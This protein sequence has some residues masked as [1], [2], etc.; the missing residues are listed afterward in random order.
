MCRF[1]VVEGIRDTRLL[2][3]DGIDQAKEAVEGWALARLFTLVG[4]PTPEIQTWI[5]GRGLSTL[6]PREYYV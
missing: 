1:V 4:R 6:T 5:E 2:R 3:R